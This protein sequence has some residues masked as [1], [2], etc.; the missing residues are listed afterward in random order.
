MED[1]REFLGD[2]TDDQ[3]PTH[4]QRLVLL[5]DQVVGGGEVGAVRL[6]AGEGVLHPDEQMAEAL[7][8]GRLRSVRLDADEELALKVDESVEVEED[9]DDRVSR[10]HVLALELALVV[11]RDQPTPPLPPTHL[12][13]LEV[14][15]ILALRVEDLAADPSPI[16]RLLHLRQL[17]LLERLH[18]PAAP[19]DQVDDP[20]D[21][22][23]DHDRRRRVVREELRDHEHRVFGELLH[24]SARPRCALRTFGS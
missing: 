8:L 19:L 3:T 4:H 18:Q 15:H 2:Q 21:D 20:A 22:L 17:G 1:V 7:I 11:L 9:G 10:Q 5:Q 13:H 23:D 12:Q 16:V 6:V 24:R 14:L